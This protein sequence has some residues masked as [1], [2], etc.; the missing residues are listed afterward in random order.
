[1]PEYY[2]AGRRVPALFN[3]IA[4]A[5]DGISAATCINLASILVCSFLGG[6]RAIS[7]AQV[8]QYIIILFAYLIPLIWLPAKYT[9]APIPQ[10]AY[11]A[12]VPKLTALEQKLNAD[13]GEQEVRA[14]FKARVD[15]LTAQLNNLPIFCEDGRL[16]AQQRAQDLK[17]N[18]R[19]THAT[20]LWRAPRR[21]YHRP[22]RF[23]AINRS[24]IKRNNFRRWCSA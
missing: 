7:W 6:M 1:M 10:V 5:A 8:A 19:A 3:G 2:V 16:E 24:D 15:K 12:V 4:T 11:G 14:L 17:R 20:P 22:N 18:S 9:N 21:R 13:P 23:R